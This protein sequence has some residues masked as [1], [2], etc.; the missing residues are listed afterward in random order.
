MFLPLSRL[1]VGGLPLA[2]PLQ[3]SR[4]EL[5]DQL[6]VDSDSIGI[7]PSVSLLSPHLLVLH[8]HLR[9]SGPAGRCL[10]RFCRHLHILILVISRY[11][12]GIFRRLMKAAS[13]RDLE[14]AARD[15]LSTM[16]LV[17]A[18]LWF[19]YEVK[20]IEN[21]PADG[22]PALLVSGNKCVVK[23]ALLELS[24]GT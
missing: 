3:H 23:I 15:V 20:G 13:E 11:Q 12:H 18:Q 2:L 22:Q 4:V 14:R 8:C 17:K 6:A 19:G 24:I 5:V 16:W 10:I 7:H 1:L 21:L 9:V